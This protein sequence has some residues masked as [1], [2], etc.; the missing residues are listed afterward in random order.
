M[1]VAQRERKVD[2]EKL[3]IEQA[4]ILSQQIGKEIARIMDEA[5][6]KCNQILNIYG[7]QTQIG[8]QIKPLNE[9]T[10]EKPKKRGRKSKKNQES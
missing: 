9:K 8:Y 7:L 4:D 6:I 3:S 2:V 10:E 5:N 1:E